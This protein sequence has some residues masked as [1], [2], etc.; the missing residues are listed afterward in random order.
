MPPPVERITHRHLLTAIF[1]EAAVR[2]AP[3]TRVRILDAGCGNGHLMADLHRSLHALDSERTYE[4]HGFDVHDWEY[5]PNELIAQTRATLTAQIPDVSWAERV[6]S[7]STTEAWPYADGFFDIIV[8]NQV[9]EHV[10]DQDLFFGEIKRTLRPGGFSI[11]LFPSQHTLVDVHLKQPLVHWMGSRKARLNLLAFWSRLGIGS[12]RKRFAETGATLQ[13]FC[14]ENA[15]FLE[16]FTN[17]Q[18]TRALIARARK[19]GLRADLRYTT[20]FYTTHLRSATGR[21]PRLRYSIA[22]PNSFSN[23][24]AG[25]LRYVS[26]VTL[27]L[28]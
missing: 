4:I 15:D 22:R 5:G 26:C 2:F 8:S 7:L 20:E 16:R 14:N 9:L 18:T 17:Y 28:E 25:V 12:Y 24:R 11:H 27:F 19:H 23:L 21:P 10:D 3:G 13:T 1:T 6:V